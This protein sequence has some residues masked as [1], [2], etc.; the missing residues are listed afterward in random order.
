MQSKSELPIWRDIGGNG[1]AEAAEPI[2][3]IDEQFP[4]ASEVR[5]VDAG[6]AGGRSIGQNRFRPPVAQELDNCVR[7]DELGDDRVDNRSGGGNE[8]VLRKWTHLV[9]AGE[10]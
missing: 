8:H 2:L 7:R 3:G 6:E 5:R 10:P 1:Y 4:C 9:A